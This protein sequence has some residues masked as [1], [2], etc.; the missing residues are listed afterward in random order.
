[1]KFI[2]KWY[3][4]SKDYGSDPTPLPI[5]A[6]NVEEV[7]VKMLTKPR[8]PI[9][10]SDIDEMIEHCEAP[11]LYAVLSDGWMAVP[12]S[13]DCWNIEGFAN[14]VSLL[15]DPPEYDEPVEIE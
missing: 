8:A 5:T 9:T 15:D 14:A 6:P 7:R 4:G 2:S 3:P 10:E 13:T 11:A 1:M 12:E